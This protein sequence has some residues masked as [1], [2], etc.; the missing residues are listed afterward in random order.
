MATRTISASGGTRAYS[1]I[2]TWEEGAVPT[3]S[4]DVVARSDGTS[5]SVTIGAAAACRSADFSNYAGTLTQ[6]GFDWSIGTT[7]KPGSNVALKFVPGMAYSPSGAARIVFVSTQ[8]GNTITS[9]GLVPRGIFFNAAGG[10]TLQDDLTCISTVNFQISAGT[11]SSNGKT[12]NIGAF[13]ST[14]GTRNITLDGSTV[15]IIGVGTATYINIVATGLTWSAVGTTWN[16]AQ[17]GTKTIITGGQ[18][19]GAFNYTGGGSIILTGAGVFTAFTSVGATA[20]TFP[21]GVTITATAIR[22][23]GTPSKRT[24]VASASSGNTA[25]VSQA[26]GT[27]NMN[28]ASF[29]DVTFQGGATFNAWDSFNVSNVSGVTHKT[30]AKRLLAGVG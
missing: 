3:A 22:I 28:H 1:D 15:N 20:V 16:I 19:L 7:T 13:V 17:T 18:S 21:N 2:A 11:F 29:Q 25:T 14:T 9:A 5:G 6:G 12:M 23:E 10:W 8:T 27:V 24:V 4:D 30:P 26:A